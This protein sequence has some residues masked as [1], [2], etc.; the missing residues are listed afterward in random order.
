M[1]EDDYPKEAKPILNGYCVCVFDIIIK[2]DLLILR[3]KIY[4]FVRKINKIVFG[5]KLHKFNYSRKII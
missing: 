2:P 5:V 1:N 3:S 4:S